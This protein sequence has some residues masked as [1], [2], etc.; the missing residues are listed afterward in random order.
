MNLYALLML[1]LSLMTCTIEASSL[2]K[3]SDLIRGGKSPAEVFTHLL[4]AHKLV[5]LECTMEKC[6][7]CK[8][9]APQLEAIASHYAS[10][11]EFIEINVHL[12]DDILRPFHIKSAPSFIIFHR[13]RFAETLPG[14]KSIDKISKALDIYLKKDA[15]SAA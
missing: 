15:A 14:S 6:P 12:F 1:V 8:K 3:F 13:G 5:V 10:V 2:K 4:A 11:A 7:S 9:I